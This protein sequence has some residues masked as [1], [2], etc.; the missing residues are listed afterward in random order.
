MVPKGVFSR[1][2]RFGR[3]FPQLR[4]LK[5][6][7]LSISPEDLGRLG[8]PM[9]GGGMDPAQDN[10]R[11][12][13]GVT[14]LGQFLDH[15]ITFDPTSSLEQQN[16]PQAVR[17]FRTAAFEL[18]SVYGA[19]PDV[20]PFF[21][22]GGRFVTSQDGGDVP[23]NELGTAIIADPRDDENLIVSQFH[24]AF[25]RFH[26][27]V[28]GSDARGD[29]EEA[30]RIVRWHYQWIILH[31]YLPLT[32][33]ED[34]VRHIL[35]HGRRFFRFVGEPFIPVE[36]S[37]AAFR[38]GHSQVRPGYRIND[39]F[40]ASLFPEQPDAPF[41]D[42][43]LR[44]G[45]PVT[46]ERRLDPAQFFGPDAQPGRLIDGRLSTPLLRLPDTVVPPGTPD[47]LRSLAIR[48]LQRGLAF[49]LPAGQTIA[50]FMQI[51]E[52]DDN[53]LWQ[54]SGSKERIKTSDG[55][56]ASGLAPL[57]FYVLR[58]AEFEAKGQHLHGVGARIVGEVFIGLLQGD[59][60]S[61]LNH[62]PGFTPTLPAKKRGTFTLQDLFNLA[63]LPKPPTV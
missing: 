41:E 19:G 3:M 50:R 34:V 31:E 39:N 32:C 7:Q 2:G 30:Q 60:A 48:N 1:P 52:L 14:F 43:D 6:S 10:P 46:P 8:G 47:E 20:Q 35:R 24:L 53:E 22:D 63:D 42:G 25:L 54:V 17:N 23:R 15:D 26:N 5:E 13:G 9:D 61:F 21:Y 37:V 45:R 18:D 29:F 56:P 44:G 59:Q 36:F 38:F 27:F 11:L 4:S 55:Q 12:T 40:A 62:E 51:P 57:W 16:D 58:E 28:L 49:A 33:G